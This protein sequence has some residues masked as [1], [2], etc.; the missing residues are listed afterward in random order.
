VTNCP[1]RANAAFIRGMATFAASLLAGGGHDGLEVKV[2]ALVIV[3][4]VLLGVCA[5]LIHGLAAD[6][7]AVD[8]VNH[9]R[10]LGLSLRLASD[11]SV[12]LP[13]LRMC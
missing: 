2:F 3:R 7:Y 11:V 5:E 6:L 12:A 4:D 9:I 13:V 1:L 10:H 8:A